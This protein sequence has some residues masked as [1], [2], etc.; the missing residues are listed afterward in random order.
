[1]FIVVKRYG[2]SV[3]SELLPKNLYKFEP[4]IDHS[5]VKFKGLIGLFISLSNVLKRSSSIT[6]DAIGAS[7][8]SVF[9]LK[10]LYSPL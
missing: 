6:D 5:V 1:M 10:L 4:A 7:N 2:S 3:S 8:Y 9:C